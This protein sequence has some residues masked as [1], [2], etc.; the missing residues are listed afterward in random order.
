MLARLAGHWV[1]GGA[2]AGGLLLVL[3]PLLT[4]G[5]NAG[6]SWAYLALVAYM[7]HQ[8]EEHDDDR[9]RRFVNET[10]AKGRA[11]LTSAEVFLIN[12][13]G[14]WGVIALSLWL[15][16][17]LA[18][19]WALIAAWLM[20][21]NALAHIGPALAL[22]RPNPGLWTALALFLPLGLAML[23]ALSPRASLV[24]QAV[25]LGLALLIHLAIMARALRTPAPRPA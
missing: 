24:Q 13:P 3:A 16:E 18:Q 25:G 22:R 4:A 17:R 9:F 2:L 20:L 7:L 21:V 11:G 8:Y 10:A 6:G 15:A 5:L 1:Y 19:G 12:I 14:V 23:A